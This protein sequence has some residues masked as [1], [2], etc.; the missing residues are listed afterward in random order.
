LLK[1]DGI[2]GESKDAPPATDA[3]WGL[4]TKLVQPD[5]E[6]CKGSLLDQLAALG[7]ELGVMPTDYGFDL[8]ATLPAGVDPAQIE[9]CLPGDGSVIPTD[10]FS[11]NFT[12]IEWQALGDG[13]VRSSL[14]KV[15]PGTL[16]L[17]TAGLSD[18]GSVCIDLQPVGAQ[19]L[20]V[21]NALPAVQ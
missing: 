12:K 14:V 21:P 8:V 20:C 10:Q 3:F 7:G 4:I 16:V 9:P 1:L 13:S 19:P 6:S 17:G 11:L 18:D 15:G 5:G 2:P